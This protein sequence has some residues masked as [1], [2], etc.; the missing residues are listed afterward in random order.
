MPRR[1]IKPVSCPGV[2]LDSVDVQKAEPLLTSLRCLVK[3]TITRG[4][5]LKRNAEFRE[6]ICELSQAHDT[7]ALLASA[8]QLCIVATINW[9]LWW[10]RRTYSMNGLVDGLGE[11]RRNEEFIA[12]AVG[13]L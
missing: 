4:G 10:E 12:H 11:C 9:D 8:G 6:V 1:K 7:T 2:P 3:A 5:S 13:S